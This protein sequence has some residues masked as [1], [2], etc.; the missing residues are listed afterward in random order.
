MQFPIKHLCQLAFILLLFACNNHTHQDQENNS[1]KDGGAISEMI[2]NPVSADNPVD[3]ASM[4]KITFEETTFDFD[5][6][7]EGSIIEHRFKFRNTGK[8]SLIIHNARSSCGCTVPEWPEEPI[9]P[10]DAGEILVRFNT[11]DKTGFQNKPIT[12]F[13]N[14][15]PQQTVIRMR[16]FVKK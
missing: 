9:T 16:G 13:A 15:L 1:G 3:S 7:A 4:G 12:I 5:T 2:R 11:T 10:G 6:I 8:S 14:S